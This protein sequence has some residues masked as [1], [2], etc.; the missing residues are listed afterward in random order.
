MNR[1]SFSR[2]LLTSFEEPR[3][4]KADVWRRLYRIWGPFVLLA[5]ILAAPSSALGIASRIIVV[6][7]LLAE[8]LRLQGYLPVLRL[9]VM[10]VVELAMVCVAIGLS[11]ANLHAFLAGLLPGILALAWLYVHYHYVKWKV[12]E[13][14]PTGTG[15]VAS[16]PTVTQ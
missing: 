14:P 2:F 7:V 8:W 4:V 9:W 1:R 15:T 5:A 3:T 10:R 13:T 16:P 12:Q 11:L 6:A